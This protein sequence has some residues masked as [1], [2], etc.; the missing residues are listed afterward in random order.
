MPTISTETGPVIEEQEPRRSKVEGLSADVGV[1]RQNVGSN[2]SI[3]PIQPRPTRLKARRNNRFTTT[4]PERERIRNF[5]L[6]TS[7]VGKSPIDGKPNPNPGYWG[8]WQ[9]AASLGI[10]FW[11]VKSWSVKWG[12][13]T[14]RRWNRI[15]GRWQ[16]WCDDSMI[17]AWKLKMAALDHDRRNEVEKKRVELRIARASGLAAPLAVTQAEEKAAYWKKRAQREARPATVREA[18]TAVAQALFQ[19]PN[20]KST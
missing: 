6:G 1:Y 20:A 11:T 12:F 4:V 13:P 9:I 8:W 14:F 7:K 19:Q 17:L 15:T 5:Y 3:D 18:A 10:S 16:Q 2:S